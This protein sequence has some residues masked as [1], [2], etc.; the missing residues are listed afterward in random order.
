MNQSESIAKLA[1][2]LAKAQGEMKAA[3]KNR[4]NPFF[5]SKFADLES[6]WDACREPLSKNGLSVSQPTRIDANGK[7][8]LST[9]LLHSSGEWISSELPINP[10]KNDPQGIGSAISYMKRFGLSA[11]VGVATSDV[12]KTD[13]TH[14]DDDGESAVG[15]GLRVN[16]KFGLKEL[17][18]IQILIE[19]LGMPLDTVIAWCHKKWPD[20]GAW[21]SMNEIQFQELLFNLKAKVDRAATNDQGG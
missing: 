2:A 10:V 9:M 15:R 5:K 12:E 14:E 21:E 1:E 8:I 19:K 16:W 18:A 20:L 6:V 7:L 3:F 11:V 17:Q 4:E 13:E